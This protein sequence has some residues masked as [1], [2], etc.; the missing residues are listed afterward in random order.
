DAVVVGGGSENELPVYDLKP[1]QDSIYE[2]GVAHTFTPL[3]NG[4]LTLWGRHVNNVLD[5]TQIGNTPLFTVFNSAGGQSAGMELRLNGRT[6]SGNSWYFSYGTSYSIA[7][8]ISGGTFNFPVDQLQGA[9][10]WALEDHDQ[11]NTIN[12]AYTFN[13]SPD[14]RFASLQALFGSGFPVQFE[15][16]TGR[17]PVHWELGASYGQ[18]A[19]RNAIGWEV[20]GTNLLNHIYLIKVSNGFNSTQY[21]AGRQVD[22]KFTAPVY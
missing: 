18:P 3:V 2:A 6:Y 22:V 1:E 12:T 10:S 5:T 7:E 4:F 9:N 19:R 11:T 15:N 8:G 14:G 20:S 13:L 21:S 16:G 17:L